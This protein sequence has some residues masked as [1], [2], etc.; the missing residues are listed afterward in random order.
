M[1][2]DARTSSAYSRTSALELRVLNTLLAMGIDVH[3]PQELEMNEKIN[4]S[5]DLMAQVK[6]G[7]IYIHSF[8]LLLDSDPTGEHE[9]SLQVVRV[10]IDDLIA[11]L[12]NL[13]K[14]L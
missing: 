7:V 3:I 10:E 4:I 5:H 11:A 14:E 13:K 1:N 8:H 6:L 9:G 2:A 12:Q